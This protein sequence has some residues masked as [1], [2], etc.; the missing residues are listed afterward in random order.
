[1]WK[2]GRVENLII[3]ND[4]KVRTADICLPGAD[5]CSV[6]SICC[7]PLE[8]NDGQIDKLNETEKLRVMMLSLKMQGIQRKKIF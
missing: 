5:M 4:G 3:S 2:L 6:L 7:Y 8:L 1:M